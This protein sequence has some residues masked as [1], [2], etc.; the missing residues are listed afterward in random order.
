MTGAPSAQNRRPPRL[1]HKK[2][3]AG[4]QR[5]KARRVKVSAD[6]FP[7]VNHQK[8]LSVL[9]LPFACPLSALRQHSLYPR[10]MINIP[11]ATHSAMRLNLHVEDAIAIMYP[12]STFTTKSPELQAARHHC[13]QTP[14]CNQIRSSQ[15]SSSTKS[16]L[17]R[18]STILSRLMI[19]WIS[20]NHA[21]DAS[22]NYAC[23][24]IT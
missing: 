21:N 17:P 20:L 24:I 8:P 11:N 23:G 4:C 15:S 19:S 9:C 10:V 22:W 1:N 6:P 16:S 13:H 18:P 14:L 5:C 7:N 12:V 2:S 3:R